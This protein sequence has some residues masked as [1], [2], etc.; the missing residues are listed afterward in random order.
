MEGSS[1]RPS[2]RVDPQ[3]EVSVLMSAGDQWMGVKQR[4]VVT[5]R[6]CIWPQQVEAQYWNKKKKTSLAAPDNET[7]GGIVS[8]VHF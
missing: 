6:M 7:F 4:L 5:A 1:A 2:T 3:V 8:C